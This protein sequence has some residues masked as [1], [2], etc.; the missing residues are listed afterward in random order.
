MSWGAASR[1][2][3]SPR[4]EELPFSAEKSGSTAQRTM[5][6]VHLQS[7]APRVSQPPSDPA[8]HAIFLIDDVAP[9]QTDT[10]GGEIHTPTLTPIAK[11]KGHLQS[12]SYAQH[13]FAYTRGLINWTQPS[14]SG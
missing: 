11:E 6:I 5:R 9:G 13:A 4:R 1:C 12:L 10:Y 7:T 3:P 2:G 14:S 8:E